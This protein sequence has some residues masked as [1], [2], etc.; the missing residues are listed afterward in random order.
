MKKL[1]LIILIMIVSVE[2]K[3]SFD[4]YQNTQYNQRDTYDVRVISFNKHYIKTHKYRKKIGY[5]NADRARG[6]LP[7]MRKTY[8][9]RLGYK[10][11][12]D[13]GGFT[14]CI[15]TNKKPWGKYLR[16]NDSEI[17][18]IFNRKSEF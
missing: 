18:Q 5:S 13:F 3:G 8:K 10:I 16:L 11:C 2:A 9:R 14:E 6:E 15:I 4:N 7:F 12:L 1:I 17:Q